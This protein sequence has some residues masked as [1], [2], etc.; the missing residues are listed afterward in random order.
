LSTGVALLV[1][2]AALL[3][4]SWNAIVKAGRDTFLDT[5]LVTSGAAILSAI[6][7]VLAPLPASASWPY[8]AASV[9][10]H[11]VYFSF[12]AA[13]YRVGDMSYAY[14]LMR[15]TGP[16]LV[17]IASGPLIGEYL[18]VGA[19][20]GVLTICA[21]VLV[22][23]ISHHRPQGAIGAS[24]IFAL[25]NAVVIAAYTL[26]DGAGARLSGH[27][28]AYTAWMF[29]LTAPFLLLW[30]LSRRRSDLASTMRSRWPIGLLGGA[31]TL[32]AYTLVIW[33]M[34]QAPV[35]VVAALRETAILF[36]AALSAL[37]LKEQFGW[38]RNF[39]AAV[40]M[41]GVVILRLS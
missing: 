22:L 32:G 29:L 23:A 16:L 21:G 20:V 27:A 28:I 9:V 15:G 19:W 11:V 34:T 41:I 30:G 25:G 8:L 38:A 1:L 18:S 10:I 37:V 26:V 40:I 5:V 31:C 17:A 33:A 4:A 7:I 14:P 13:A 12:V 39:A 3:H 24:T 6:V 36:G 2:L 35:A